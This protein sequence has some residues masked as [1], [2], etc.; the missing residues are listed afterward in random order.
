MIRLP[1]QSYP[2]L[3]FLF[4]VVFLGSGCITTEKALDKQL[5]VEKNFFNGTDCLEKGLLPQARK[6]FLAA[7]ELDSSIPK[8]HNA[9]GRVYLEEN[10]Q[11]LAEKEFLKALDLDGQFFDAHTQ[12]G[13]LYMGQ[14]KFDEAIDSFRKLL[15]FFP[16]FPEFRTQNLLG[17][18]YYEKGDYEQAF[19]SLKKSVTSAPNY[20]PA[21]YNLGL[22]LF[23][24]GHEE[25]AAR[26]FNQAV[27]LSP[28]FSPAHYQL[29][30]LYMKKKMYKE[31]RSEFLEV[32]ATSQ[33]E[34]AKK[35]AGD[36][37]RI[38]E[39]IQK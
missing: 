17:W 33:D 31:A 38:I 7:I 25:E 2:S 5:Q 32:L 22:T 14:K 26:Q 3:V 28:G 29:G 6:E 20:V 4:L 8:L 37:I 39:G 12:L 11:D 23:A 9:L 36:Y 24:F 35:T 1:S 21:R 16:Q 15:K 10:K 19:Q 34:N 30:L 18:A 27:K 13:S